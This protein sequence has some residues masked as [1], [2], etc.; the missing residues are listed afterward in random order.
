[1]HGGGGWPQ[2]VRGRALNGARRSVSDAA[3]GSQL[4]A[5]PPLAPRCSQLKSHTADHRVPGNGRNLL[6]RTQLSD[7]VGTLQLWQPHPTHPAGYGHGNRRAV[8]CNHAAGQEYM[9]G[10]S[11]A[12]GS[13]KRVCLSN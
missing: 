10:G 5:S 1:M 12:A 7:T 3:Q 4:D 6:A 13:A 2:L 9:L 11:R 8:A